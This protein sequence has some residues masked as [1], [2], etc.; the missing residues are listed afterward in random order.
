MVISVA[1]YHNK[2]EFRATVA[3]VPVSW[4]VLARGGTFYVTVGSVAGI[5]GIG[6]FTL[7]TND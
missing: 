2:V 1:T 7:L 4:T 5:S 3:Q 6:R